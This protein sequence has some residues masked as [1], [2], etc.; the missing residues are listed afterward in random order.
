MVIITALIP[1]FIRK[2]DPEAHVYS[3]LLGQRSIIGYVFKN[4]N[5]G[6][7][8]YVDYVRGHFRKEGKQGVDRSILKEASLRYHA[9]IVKTMHNEQKKLK[10]FGCEAKKWL[11]WVEANQ[12]WYHP[13]DERED[14]GNIPLYMLV[15]N[16]ETPLKSL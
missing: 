2:V 4:P 16:D 15:D 3:K 1:A 13:P 5:T 8:Y 7:F 14:L 10:F 12:S 11:N 9:I 6:T